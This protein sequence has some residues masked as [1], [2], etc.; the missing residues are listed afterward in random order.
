MHYEFYC[1]YSSYMGSSTHML[2]SFGNIFFAVCKGMQM[3]LNYKIMQSEVDTE[4][5]AL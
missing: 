1:I 2:Q 5:E 3:Y 4:V